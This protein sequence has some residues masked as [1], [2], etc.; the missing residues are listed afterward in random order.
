M[1]PKQR[2]DSWKQQKIETEEARLKMQ[3]SYH[4]RQALAE[5][6]TAQVLEALSAFLKGEAGLIV[7]KSLDPL[8]NHETIMIS[9]QKK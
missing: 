8:S 4:E 9:F 7:Q 5:T 6:V 2:Y 3:K 1:T